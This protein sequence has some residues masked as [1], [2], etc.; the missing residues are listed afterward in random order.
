MSIGN[1]SKRIILDIDEC[2][3]YASKE[4]FLLLNKKWKMKTFKMTFIHIKCGR[5]FKMR[6]VEFE[7]G[8][9]C[10]KC[11]GKMKSTLKEISSFCKDKGYK[12][13]SKEYKNANTKMTFK[14]LDCGYEFSTTWSAFK[15]NKGLGC[16]KCSGSL[17]LNIEYCL[18]I[19]KN[20]GYLL[21]EKN[22]INTITNM[23][24]L[25]IS[26][27]NEF[28][29]SWN[30][31]HPD[32][33]CKICSYKK[34]A[35]KRNDNKRKT[36]GSLGDS[37]PEL[38]KEWSSK[39]EKSPFE[40]LSGSGKKVWWT[41]ERHEDYI[42]S[43]ASRTRKN[44]MGSGCPVCRQS[45]G[46]KRIFSFLISCGLK[47]NVDFFTEKTFRDCRNESFLPFDFYIPSLNILIEY[48]GIQHF[49]PVRFGG[50]SEEESVKNLAKQKIKDKIKTKYC[51]SKKIRLVRISYL[52]YDKIEE[53]LNKQM[54]HLL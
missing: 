28:I 47:E 9:R 52:K 4:G 5:K 15:S 13:L 29:S 12:L 19:S 38:I 32:G 50:I 3:E 53:I 22:Y 51:M 44:S 16:R 8:R 24:F 1:S 41:C 42:S 18:E 49:V 39:N 54:T 21:L 30:N 14:H 46:E 6:W 27:G 20:R 34:S 45:K 2:K 26:C 37:F 23:K 31:F 35:E 10:S 7:R 40:Y 25:H 48:D 17:K 11:S 43:I 33:G 36:V